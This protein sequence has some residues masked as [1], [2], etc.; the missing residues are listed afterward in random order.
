MPSHD[1][2]NRT[3]IAAAAVLATAVFILPLLARF[4]LL[5]PD[6]GLHASIAQEMVERGDWLTPRFLGEPFFDKPVFYFWCQAAS[7]KLFGMNETAV[8]LP[9]LMFG[10]LGAITTLLVGRRMFNPLT[11]WTAGIIYATTILPT[12]LAQAAAHDVALVPC[13]NLA[14]LGFWELDRGRYGKR[15]SPIFAGAK[16]GTVPRSRRAAAYLIVAIGILLGL[17]ILIK[18]LIGVAMVGATYGVYLLVRRRFS[19][20]ACLQGLAVLIVAGL[21]AASWYLPMEIEHSGYLRYFFYERHVLGFASATQIHGEAP[22]WYYLPILLGGGLPWIGY[23]PMTLRDALSPFQEKKNGA[24]AMLLC[25]LIVCTALLSCSHS[26]L[27]T[28]LWPVFPAAA[29]LAAVAWSRLIDGTLAAK[30]RISL[31]NT[32][33]LSSVAGPIVLPLVIFVA[34]KVFGVRFSPWVWTALIAAGFGALAPLWFCKR[35]AW[36]AM[37]IASACSIAVQFA[38]VLFFALPPLA[39]NFTARD[40]ADY[41]NRKGKLPVRLLVAEER[42]GSFVFYLDPSLRANL[43]TDRLDMLFNDRPTVE[44][45]G[46]VIVLPERR[47]DQADQYP[48]LAGLKF[49]KVGRYRLY[50]VMNDE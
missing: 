6:E 47:A 37:M 1:S 2:N 33:F 24:I 10:L 35:K 28:Y 12:A 45:P 22:W 42:L 31:V 15:D 41:F 27:A 29:M 4:P 32:F 16:I 13:V 21:I 34:Q 23:L 49:E 40:L 11:G 5:D 14:M 39:E 30:P 25:W 8:R 19:L 50:E 38:A 3:L 26:K 17:S 48:E 18:G 7:L 36:Q 9:G 46:T 44:P 43:K 20:T